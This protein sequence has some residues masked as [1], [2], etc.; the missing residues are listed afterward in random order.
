MSE[1]HDDHMTFTWDAIPT[2]IGLAVVVFAD[3]D[4][5]SFH[6]TDTDPQWE[7]ERIA[8]ALHDT[9]AHTPGAGADLAA[10]LDEYFDGEREAFDVTLDWRL[11]GGGFTRDALDA[12]TRIPYGETQSYGEVA[13]HA[14]RPRAAR[15]VGSACRTTPFS[16]IVPVHRV[17]RS[18]GSV[19]EYGSSPDAKKFLLDLEADA[20]A[21][22]A[23]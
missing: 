2:P 22:V 9:P 7:I 19:G 4:I 21:R 16:V 14:G 17:I 18:D 5:I 20:L 11:A 6:I 10:Q 1:R 13:M 8:L 3:S 12:I 15:S 23:P